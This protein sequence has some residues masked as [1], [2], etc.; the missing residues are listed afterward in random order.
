VGGTGGRGLAGGGGPPEPS[1]ARAWTKLACGEIGCGYGGRSAL[2]G[3]SSNARDNNNSSSS[4]ICVI[5]DNALECVQE[6]FPR[7]FVVHFVPL[8]IAIESRRR[9]RRHHYYIVATTTTSLA[10][11]CCDGL[12]KK[13]TKKKI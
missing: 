9:R 6:N 8:A 2:G 3:R 4:S 13:K 5:D 12:E 1:P 7:P 10:L 11:F